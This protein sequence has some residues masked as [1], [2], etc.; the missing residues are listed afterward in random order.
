MIRIIKYMIRIIKYMISSDRPGWNPRPFACEANDVPLHHSGES[1]GSQKYW[2]YTWRISKTKA[3]IFENNSC[4]QETTGKKIFRPR[5]TE[6]SFRES[7]F[8]SVTKAIFQ[9]VRDLIPPAPPPSP[10]SYGTVS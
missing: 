6:K 4:N 1:L 3:G 5:M 7:L 2:M 10:G 9:K 8:S